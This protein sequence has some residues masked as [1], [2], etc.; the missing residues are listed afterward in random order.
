LDKVHFRSDGALLD[1]DITLKR[2]SV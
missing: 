1:D 2:K